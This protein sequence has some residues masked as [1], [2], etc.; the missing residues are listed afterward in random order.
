MVLL[1]N[2]HRMIYG[3]ISSLPKVMNRAMCTYLSGWQASMVRVCWVV[4]SYWLLSWHSFN[5]EDTATSHDTEDLRERGIQTEN[6]S[7]DPYA[8]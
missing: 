2:G 6:R 7:M 8:K 4:I 5:L 3:A 1:K